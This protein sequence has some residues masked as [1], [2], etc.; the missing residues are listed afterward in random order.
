MGTHT[1]ITIGKYT[2]T[3]DPRRPNEDMK[4]LYSAVTLSLTVKNVRAATRQWAR[5]L[6]SDILGKQKNPTD[7]VSPKFMVDKDDKSKAALWEDQNAPKYTK[8]PCEVAENVA[9]VLK[10]TNNMRPTFRWVSVD[11]SVMDTIDTYVDCGFSPLEIFFIVFGSLVGAIG[12]T[13]GAVL[14]SRSK[15]KCGGN[16][17]GSCWSCFGGAGSGAGSGGGSGGGI[18]AMC[19][20]CCIATSGSGKKDET[21]LTNQKSKEEKEQETTNGL[22]NGLTVPGELN[23]NL[24]TQTNPA[25]EQRRRRPSQNK[26][27]LIKKNSSSKR[28][29]L[30]KKNTNNNTNNNTGT[31]DAESNYELPPMSKNNKVSKKKKNNKES[32]D[33]KGT[34]NK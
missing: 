10:S 19:C 15:G 32:S 28:N 30:S 34:T 2:D 20:C 16:T 18:A 23:I 5:A 13:S 31:T 22:M 7:N 3:L 27:L 4:H 14:F 33:L 17:D 25:P 6:V 21:K 29:S 8:T 1:P 24:N 11:M 9:K 12:L 26:T